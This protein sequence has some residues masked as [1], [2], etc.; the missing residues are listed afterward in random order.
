MVSI[1]L[2]CLASVSFSYRLLIEAARWSSLV[3]EYSVMSSYPFCRIMLNAAVM[4]S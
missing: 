2:M 3:W 1:V 4:K